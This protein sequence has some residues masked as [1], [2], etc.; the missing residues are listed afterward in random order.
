[1]GYNSGFKGLNKLL[2][3]QH[4]F[5][6][7]SFWV[8]R[9]GYFARWSNFSLQ[10]IYPQNLT[11]QKVGSIVTRLRDGRL[12]VRTTAE[13]RIF[14]QKIRTLTGPLSTVYLIGYRCSLPREISGWGL[15]LTTLCHLVPKF[16]MCGVE[17]SILLYVLTLRRLMSYIYGAPIVDV[18]RSHTTTQH[19]R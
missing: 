9:N 5:V 19:S 10:L 17:H 11:I 3:L 6:A 12:W 15:N 7:W 4:L 2:N 16:R 1:M 8:M 13:A 14:S 18:S